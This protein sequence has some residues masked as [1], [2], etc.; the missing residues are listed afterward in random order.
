M[1]DKQRT[2]IFIN[3]II[4][5]IASTMMATALTTALP[6]MI[7]E[8]NIS[9]T[10]G[11]WLTSGYSLAMGIVM[12]L[13]A[14]LITQFPTKKLYLTAIV[15]FI[16]GLLIAV[17]APNFTILMI[18]RLFQ[19][20]GNGILSA[21]AQVILLTI[22]PPERR[23]TIMGWYGLSIG[24]APVIAPTIAGVIVDYSGWRMIFYV[25][26]VIMILSFIVASLAFKNVLETRKKHFD[27]LSFMISAIA[28]AGIT[29]GI[30]N[31]GTYKFISAGVLLPILLG[32]IAIV[33]FARR[34]LSQADPFLDLRILKHRAFTLSLIGS[35]L[36]Y[37]AMMGSSIILPLLIQSVEGFSATVSG[38][39]TLPGSLAMA[40]LSPFAGK[41]Y[42][43]F[44]IRR[45]F[46]TG[47]LGL[48][49]SNLC[50]VFININTSLL[51]IAS[52]NII[53][54]LA[55]GCLMMPLITWGMSN[56]LPEMMAHG[57]ALLTS[58]R[59]IAGAIGSAIFVSLMTFVTNN[60]QHLSAQGAAMHG[61][62]AAFLGMTFGAVA[63]FI[64]ALL[65]IKKTNTKSK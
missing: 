14:F 5:V 38:L 18:G 47:S 26:I 11:Q 41:I 12:P 19:A 29:I 51:M 13:T 43:R 15:L 59:T 37:F 50:M 49:I 9:V 32:I 48:I 60:S 17:L 54:S 44:G 27:T 64:V 28:Y 20:C 21:M 3:I 25:V 53:R 16:V 8:F 31:I 57:T 7:T 56:F 36:L 39:V 62:N 1:R 2:W 6:V 46:I 58:L 35:M 30:G 23:G 33:I 10:T 65:P 63:L 61:V 34:Q 40:I 45:L 22:Y 24:A 42:D 52:F 4:T 55:I